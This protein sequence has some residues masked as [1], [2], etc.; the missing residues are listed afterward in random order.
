M[1]KSSLTAAERETEGGASQGN[2][3]IEEWKG[4][5]ISLS[6]SSSPREAEKGPPRSENIDLEGEGDSPNTPSDLCSI[7]FLEGTFGPIFDFWI[8]QRLQIRRPYFDRK[9]SPPLA[10]KTDSDPRGRRRALLQRDEIPQ[11][12]LLLSGIPP[13][14]REEENTVKVKRGKTSNFFF[15]LFLRQSSV[16][17][18]A[19]VRRQ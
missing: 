12:F 6:I 15:L 5:G 9:A 17:L 3:C 1:G 7:A 14:G 18:C 16:C 8:Y 4:R 19:W 13:G 10:R 2:L 11:P